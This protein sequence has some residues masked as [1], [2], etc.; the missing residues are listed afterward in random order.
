MGQAE[1]TKELKR[2]K[3]NLDSSVQVAEQKTA[4]YIVGMTTLI[5]TGLTLAEAVL[6][7][8]LEPDFRA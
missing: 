3:V 7:G 4:R 6:V 2:F 8:C 5:A 1:M